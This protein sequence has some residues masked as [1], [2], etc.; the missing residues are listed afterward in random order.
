MCFCGA[1]LDKPKLRVIFDEMNRKDTISFKKLFC[2]LLCVIIFAGIGIFQKAIAQN[3]KAGHSTIQV[4]GRA[5]SHDKIDLNKKLLYQFYAGFNPEKL[6]AYFQIRASGMLPIKCGTPFVKEYLNKRPQLASRTVRKIE[7]ILSASQV[8]QQHQSR[9]GKF[10]IF[11]ET[12]GTNAVPTGDADNDGIPDYVEWT[13]AAADSSWRHQV[14][15]IGFTNP[16]MGSTDP[17]PIFIEKLSFYGFTSTGQNRGYPNSTYIVINSQLDKPAFASNDAVNPVRGAVQVTV[18]HE[19]KHAIQYAATNWQGEPDL[20]AEMDAVLM[21]EETYDP[22][23]DYYNYIDRDGSIF[24]DPQESFYPGTYHDVTWAIYFQERFGISFWENVWGFIEQNSSTTFVDAMTA[25]LDNTTFEQEYI[26]SH[27]W[28]F[29]SGSRSAAEYG[30][31]ERLNYPTAAIN[32][33]FTGKDSVSMQKTV[34]EF[35]A[36]Y[37]LV[38]P[39]Q[40]IEGVVEVE[41][42]Y[43]QP[44]T[45]LGLLAYFN[46]GTTAFKTFTGSSGNVISGG[47]NWTWNRIDKLGIVVTNSSTDEATGYTLVITSSIPEEITLG[48]NYPNPFTQKTTIPLTLPK[49]AE[50]QIKIFDITGRLV[51]I[52]ID[53]ELP[54]GDNTIPFD[55]SDLASGLYFYQV[56]VDDEV[57]VKKMTYIK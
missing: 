6:P 31:S 53:K 48:Q 16:I 25:N 29:A 11:Y 43:T 46:D 1:I 19:F 42:S 56:M 7:N 10:V 13:A 5:F 4:I 24:I 15:R 37:I 55:P 35:A 26:Q 47:T 9:S 8:Q 28:H 22:V 23:N 52:L 39:M 51:K 45:G 49:E 36:N 27:L 18:A 17:Y 54:A 34:P 2:R 57:R 32:I 21:E 12:S 33:K 3:V 50:V 14:Q 44:S 41:V 40:P 30:F 20:W 38:D